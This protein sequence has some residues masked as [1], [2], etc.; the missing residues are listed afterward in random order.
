MSFLVVV[1][2][3]FCSSGV[4]VVA[5]AGTGVGAGVTSGFPW[6]S[7]SGGLSPI[8]VF[9]FSSAGRCVGV[10]GVTW[11]CNWSLGAVVSG[12]FEVSGG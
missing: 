10:S 3:P 2:C 12:F 11:R 6:V 5:C 8:F 7:A 4:R 9:S 1:L